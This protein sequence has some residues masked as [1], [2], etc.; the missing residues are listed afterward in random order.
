MLKNHN[1]K[2][3]VLDMVEEDLHAIN[4]VKDASMSIREFNKIKYFEPKQK[5]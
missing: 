4:E 5:K 1:K 2:S 3:K